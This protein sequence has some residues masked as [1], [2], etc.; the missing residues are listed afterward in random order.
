MRVKVRY[1]ATIPTLVALVSCGGP[2]NLPLP[3][4]SAVEPTSE[5]TPEPPSPPP[6]ALPGPGVTLS[7]RVLEV[8]PDGTR[9]PIRVLKVHVEVDVASVLDPQ[10]GGWAPVDR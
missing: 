2:S 4:P 3:G 8:L 1:V 5:F 6:L 10:R 7:G 9:R